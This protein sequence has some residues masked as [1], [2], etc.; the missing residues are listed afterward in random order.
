MDTCPTPKNISVAVLAI[1]SAAAILATQQSE[2]PYPSRLFL[3]NDER[4]LKDPAHVVNVAA[5]ADS[6]VNFNVRPYVKSEHYWDV[7]S[8]MQEKIKLAFDEKGISIP[9]PQRDL[10]IISKSDEKPVA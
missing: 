10:H 5:L 9:Y 7:Y 4:V 3:N 8:D 2:V 6:S 1:P